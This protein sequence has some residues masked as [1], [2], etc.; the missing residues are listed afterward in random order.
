MKKFE[1]VEH[2]ADIGFRAFGR[3]LEEAF[4]NAAFAL[5][6]IVTDTEKIEQKREVSIRLDAEDLEALLFDWLDYFIYL[7][8]AEDF[9][10]SAF[11]VEQI[12]EKKDGYTL[13]AK[14]WGE[15]FN[16]E[17]HGPGTEVKA[18]TYHLM[19]IQHGPERCSVQVILDI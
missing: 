5:T 13:E 10:A 12:I 16:P 15:Q 4:E 1:W 2:P 7:F 14:A 19:E 17:K 3:D 9:V 11:E 6:E 18:V 8:D